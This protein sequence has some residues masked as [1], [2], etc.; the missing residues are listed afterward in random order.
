MS[1]PCPLGVTQLGD[2]PG[3]VRLSLTPGRA[4]DGAV[5]LRHKDTGVPTDWPA[6]TQT[7]LWFS[8]GTGT[9]RA[10]PGVFDGSWLRFSMTGTATAQIP[11]GYKVAVELNYGTDPDGWRVWLVGGCD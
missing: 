10:V 11:R 5:Q 9:G 4:F 1:L 8:W 2:T 7:R 6:G 3:T